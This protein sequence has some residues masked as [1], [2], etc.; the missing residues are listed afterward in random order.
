MKNLNQYII[1]KFKITKDTVKN[2]LSQ[3][4][5]DTAV[6]IIVDIC[7]IYLDQHKNLVNAIENWVIEN[8]ITN[9]FDT[10]EIYWDKKTTYKKAH[11]INR[12]LQGEYEKHLINNPTVCHNIAGRNKIPVATDGDNSSWEIYCDDYLDTGIKYKGNLLFIKHFKDT[13]DKI[14]YVFVE[15]DDKEKS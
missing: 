6:S 4:D 8:K 12:I 9:I 3:S 15:K 5:I 2:S 10:V 1:E 11:F 7:G 14:I 13:K